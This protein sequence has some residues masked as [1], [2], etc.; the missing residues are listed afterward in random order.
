MYVFRECRRKLEELTPKEVLECI[1]MIVDKNVCVVQTSGIKY[2][3]YLIP[4]Y[5]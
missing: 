5:S 4:Q 2:N 3:L 1:Q